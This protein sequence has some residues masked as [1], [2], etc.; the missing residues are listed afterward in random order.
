MGR[1]CHAFVTRDRGVTSQVHVSRDKRDMSR[2][3]HATTTTPHHTT[4]VVT[5]VRGC[6]GDSQDQVQS[7]TRESAIG[8]GR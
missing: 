4:S 7:V 1:D 5:S 6:C 8:L 2:V 3:S